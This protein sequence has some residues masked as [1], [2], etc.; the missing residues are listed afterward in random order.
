MFFIADLKQINIPTAEAMAD[1]ALKATR[2]L[3]M[4][5]ERFA[6]ATASP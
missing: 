4:I 1:T 6:A 3:K 2:V 5:I